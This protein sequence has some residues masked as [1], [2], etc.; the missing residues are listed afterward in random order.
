MNKATQILLANEVMAD[1]TLCMHRA[2][3]AG[4]RSA[5]AKNFL[6]VV[7]CASEAATLYE[8]HQHDRLQEANLLVEDATKAMMVLVA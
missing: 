2:K 6:L 5:A 3:R 4:T 7:K 8:V 1:A